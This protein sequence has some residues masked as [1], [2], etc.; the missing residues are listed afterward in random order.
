MQHSAI[1]PY[2]YT[3]R[4]T[5]FDHQTGASFFLYLLECRG[6]VADLLRVYQDISQSEE[7]YGYGLA[8]LVDQWLAYLDDKFEGWEPVMFEH[9]EGWTEILFGEE[10]HDWMME[11][12]GA[13]MM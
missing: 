12:F 9:T 5:L 10:Y 11:W 4:Q 3:L 7:V 13:N 6:T 8:D 1:D 2:Y